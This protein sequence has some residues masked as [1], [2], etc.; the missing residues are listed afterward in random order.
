M[1][2]LRQLTRSALVLLAFAAVP[3]AAADTL[4]EIKQAGAVNFGY[5]PDAAPFAY[6]SSDGTAK[7]YSVELCQ[8][9]ARSIGRAAGVQNLTVNFV[10]VSAAERFTA[11]ASKKI[12]VLCEATTITFSRRETMD[13]SL[14]TFGTGASVLVRSE[15]KELGGFPELAGRK[16]GVL[17]GTTTAQAL[18][19]ALTALNVKA[20]V[21]IFTS[22]DLGLAALE[23]GG[24]DA[25]FADRELLVGLLKKSAAPDKLAI[26]QGQFTYEPY[27]L[28]MRKGEDR[29]HLAVDRALA[30]LFASGAA[31]ELVQRN[32]GRPASPD[33]QMIYTIQSFPD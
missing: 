11:L 32:F 25:Y 23:G 29:L 8:R 13:F 15:L 4:D 6:L 30:Q 26:S 1:T 28:A 17:V 21:Q 12:D 3:P 14:V 5:R 19:G 18:R 24:I 2:S 16:V 9:V 10:Q 33:L 7:G 31:A 22:H 27:G 20:E